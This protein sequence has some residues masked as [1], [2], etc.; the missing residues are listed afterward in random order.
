M[1]GAVMVVTINTAPVVASRPRVSRWGVYYNKTYANWLKT[2]KVEGKDLR[3][4]DGPCIITVEQVV[5]KPRTTK[6]AS[7]NGDIDNFAKGPLD[8][9]TKSELAWVDDKQIVAMTAIKRFANPGET[10]RSIITI[11]PIEGEQTH[12]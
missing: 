8:L 10:P 6:L 7:P 5:E 3:R 11:M 4:F 1:A 9:I 2:A 12:G